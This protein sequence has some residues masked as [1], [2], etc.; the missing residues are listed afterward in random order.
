MGAIGWDATG[1]FGGALDPL[2]LWP[3]CKHVFTDDEDPCN[4]FS[5]AQ[6]AQLSGVLCAG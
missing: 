4:P 5:R 3:P 6:A 1:G 2:P